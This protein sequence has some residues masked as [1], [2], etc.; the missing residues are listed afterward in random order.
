[1]SQ[2]KIFLLVFIDIGLCVCLLL[3]SGFSMVHR[4]YKRLEHNDVHFDVTEMIVSSA[5]GSAS[6]TDPAPT[7]D[8]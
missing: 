1:L 3:I 5:P 8:V 6:A 4:V 7:R 2:S